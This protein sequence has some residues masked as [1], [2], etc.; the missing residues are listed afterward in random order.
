M[1]NYELKLH[2]ITIATLENSNLNPG[3]ALMLMVHNLCEENEEN[4]EQEQQT[5]GEVE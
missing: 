4:E 1:R 3:E 5:G 2:G